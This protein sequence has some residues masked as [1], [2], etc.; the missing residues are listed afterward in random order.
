MMMC[1]PHIDVV[2]TP[3]M[4]MWQGEGKDSFM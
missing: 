4:I 1:M 2:P 3:A